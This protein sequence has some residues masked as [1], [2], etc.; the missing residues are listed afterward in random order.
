MTRFQLH[1]KAPPGAVLRARHTCARVGPL[2]LLRFGS[3]EKL[4]REAQLAR[5]GE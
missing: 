1:S 3:L 5:K 2:R 4:E